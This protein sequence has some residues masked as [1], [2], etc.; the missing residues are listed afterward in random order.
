MSEK[1]GRT[2]RVMRIC[3]GDPYDYMAE[4]VDLLDA[5]EGDLVR[6]YPGNLEALLAEHTG[7]EDVPSGETTALQGRI[8]SPL[9]VNTQ[10]FQRALQR[11][12]DVFQW[13]F[14]GCVWEDDDVD[15]D[16]PRGV[17][18]IYVDS[19]PD[20]WLSAKEACRIKDVESSAVT[21]AII[22]GDI[23]AVMQRSTRRRFIA[24]DELFDSWN[25]GRKRISLLRRRIVILSEILPEETALEGAMRRV[26]RIEKERFGPAHLYEGQIEDFFRSC[27]DMCPETL[28][29]WRRRIDA[30]REEVGA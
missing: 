28:D 8:L 1:E 13:T 7:D 24:P 16:P 30:I 5:E 27:V 26:A 9:E 11:G 4:M 18:Y 19:P 15:D 14:S 21:R 2:I 17:T 22:D 10:D 20:G 23:N 29:E 25:P 12:A 3:D 6:V